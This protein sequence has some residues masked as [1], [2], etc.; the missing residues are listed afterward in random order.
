MFDISCV[1]RKNLRSITMN[2]NLMAAVSGTNDIYSEH[3]LF[4]NAATEMDFANLSRS[5]IHD[6]NNLMA[7]IKGNVEMM[8]DEMPQDS[9]SR[10]ILRDI[11]EASE[12]S[13]NLIKQFFSKK[14]D[15]GTIDLNEFLSDKISILRSIAGSKVQVNLKQ[16]KLQG[17][18]KFNSVNLERILVNLVKN[19]REAIN[20]DFGK[21]DIRISSEKA[22]SMGSKISS[23]AVIKVSDNGSGMDKDVLARIFDEFFSTKKKNGTRGIGLAGVK[24]MI[25]ENN[26]FIKARSIKDR[27]TLFSIYLPLHK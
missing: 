11:S 15:S 22:V 25:E 27:G 17:V 3:M 8:L 16:N 5:M 19:A 9:S 2:N 20:S 4:S 13:K 1:K 23:Y 24:R 14:S 21:I 10:S 6:F 12:S 26:G 18:V 7:V